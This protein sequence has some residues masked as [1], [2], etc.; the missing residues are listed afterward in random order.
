M[1]ST[2]TMSRGSC[3]SDQYLATVI[4]SAI[5][6]ICMAPSPTSARAGRPGWANLAPIT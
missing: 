4:S 2:A 3:H 5:P 1:L 6:F